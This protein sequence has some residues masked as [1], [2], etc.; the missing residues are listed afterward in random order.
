MCG[1]LRQGR[2]AAKLLEAKGVNHTAATS[3]LAL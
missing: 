3:D 2:H 1:S